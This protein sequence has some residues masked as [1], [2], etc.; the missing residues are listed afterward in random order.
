MGAICLEERIASSPED[1]GQCATSKL[2]AFLRGTRPYVPECL[3][4]PEN[5][6]THK[7]L[8]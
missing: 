8:F 1:G 2:G 7:E 6:R 4:C 5:L 3:H